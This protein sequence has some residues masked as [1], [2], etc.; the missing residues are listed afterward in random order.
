VE[1]FRTSE[2]GLHGMRIAAAI[3]TIALLP[4]CVISPGLDAMCFMRITYTAGWWLSF[5]DKRPVWT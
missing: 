5:C 4:G 3:Y 1:F 2:G